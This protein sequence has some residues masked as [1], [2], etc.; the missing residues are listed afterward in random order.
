MIR[1]ATVNKLTAN[2]SY[3]G[4][5]IPEGPQEGERWI[6]FGPDGET[7]VVECERVRNLAAPNPAYHHANQL[8]W[9]PPGLQWYDDDGETWGLAWD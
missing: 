9:D 7:V 4:C 5:V 3:E 6:A 2:V 1:T 8:T